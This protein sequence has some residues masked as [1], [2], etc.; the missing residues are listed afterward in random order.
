ML[1]H[2]SADVQI[3][4]D[5]NAEVGHSRRSNGMSRIAGPQLL[6]ESS[7]NDG[8][9][10]EIIEVATG[11]T[12]VN[13][14]MEPPEL[15]SLQEDGPVDLLHFDARPGNAT[16]RAALAEAARHITSLGTVVHAMEDDIA[17]SMVSLSVTEEL[18]TS[19]PNGSD[20]QESL[21][22][23][24]TLPS[25][26]HEI[27]SSSTYTNSIGSLFGHPGVN[28]REPDFMRSVPSPLSRHQSSLFSNEMPAPMG[29]CMDNELRWARQGLHDS[30]DIH[31]IRKANGWRLVR[32]AGSGNFRAVHEILMYSD[33]D[34][35]HFITSG[36]HETAVRRAGLNQNGH[37]R[38]LDAIVRAFTKN[39]KHSELDMNLFGGSLGYRI[40]PTRRTIQQLENFNTSLRAMTATVSC[41]CPQEV[42]TGTICERVALGQSFS[43]DTTKSGCLW[44]DM[45][46]QT[47]WPNMPALAGLPT[48]HMQYEFHRS[49]E[50]DSKFFRSN[51]HVKTRAHEFYLNTVLR[52]DA[53]V[54]L[55]QRKLQ[56]EEDFKN[57]Y[58]PQNFEASPSFLGDVEAF[59]SERRLHWLKIIKEL[60]DFKVMHNFDHIK[61]F[62]SG[63]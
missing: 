31:Q 27:Y 50:L 43:P 53:Y 29:E 17:E 24:Y 61:N 20:S 21:V 35:N 38:V 13:N 36:M 9:P 60:K 1:N 55:Q 7:K 47:G 12:R 42:R 56:I 33:V 49:R 46:F 48:L 14:T 23:K 40:I 58:A 5:V 11:H 8:P 3:A 15:Q 4:V 19:A 39:G 28:I 44:G 6:Q 45:L 51:E 26:R 30:G 18:A 62:H 63:R 2:D 25:R 41:L 59:Q 37:V 16:S 34:I 57:N 10:D 52:R 32:A 54:K 22:R